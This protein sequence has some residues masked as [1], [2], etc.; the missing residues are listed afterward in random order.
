MAFHRKEPL[1]KLGTFDMWKLW[2]KE[3]TEKCVPA[4]H[5]S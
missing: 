5:F 4:T 1:G 3:N 2:E